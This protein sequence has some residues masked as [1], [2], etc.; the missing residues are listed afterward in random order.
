[1]ISAA[2]IDVPVSDAHSA[3]VAYIKSQ[4]GRKF[5]LGEHDCFTFTNGAWAAMHGSGYADHFIG[6]YADLGPKA[7]ARLMKDSFGHVGLIDALDSGLSRVEG[8]PPKGALVI[9]SSCRPYFTRYALG[10]AVG[11]AAVFLGDDDVEYRSIT[12]INGAWQCRR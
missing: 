8:F 7:F 5:E 2:V 11:S 3:L 9:S 1:M 6:K 10:I 4:R 12:E